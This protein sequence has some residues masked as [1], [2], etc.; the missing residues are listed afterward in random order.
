[1]QAMQSKGEQ[2]CRF[3]P[4]NALVLAAICPLKLLERMLQAMQGA[5]AT[6]RSC[7]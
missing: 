4:V 7:P 1:M 5:V 2:H 6:P 3:P